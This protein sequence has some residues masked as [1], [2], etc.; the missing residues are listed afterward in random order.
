MKAFKKTAFLAIAL[1]AAVA[2]LA[3]CK[4]N[5]KMPVTFVAVTSDTYNAEVTLG[6]INY[7]FQGKFVHNSNSS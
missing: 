4:S 3:G 7:K 5:A 2:G 6:E 1:S